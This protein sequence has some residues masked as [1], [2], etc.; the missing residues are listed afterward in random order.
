MPKRKSVLEAPMLMCAKILGFLLLI[1]GEI[2]R[3]QTIIKEYEVGR[4]MW[5]YSV[6]IMLLFPLLRIYIGFFFLKLYG[7]YSFK[8][9]DFKVLR[10]TQ[11]QTCML[12]VYIFPIARYHMG[13][14]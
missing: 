1:E 2:F 4:R 7:L 6:L 9:K 12:L 5:T 13:S 3:Y 10:V 8:N 14:L 11:N